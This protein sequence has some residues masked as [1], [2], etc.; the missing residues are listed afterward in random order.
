MS[1]R[2]LSE[3]ALGTLLLLPAAA[4]LV[5]IVVYPIATLFWNSLHA[6]DNANPTAA[7]PFVALSNYTR[8][9]DDERFWHSSWNTILYAIVTVP[10]ALLVGL[11]LALLANM[12]FRVKWPV[13]LGLLL[14][15]ALPL[16]FAGLIFR[17]FFE[18]QTG[19]VNDLLM[20]IGVEPLQWLSSP[21]LAFAAISIAIIWKASS[22]MALI[23]L[24][25]LQTIPRSL[26]EAADVD[27]ATRWQQFWEITLPMLLPS[28][29]VAL[30]FRTITAI[31]TFDIPFAMTGGGPGD[32]TETLA[33]YIYK[34]T[35][36][37]LDFGYGSA[38]AVLMFALSLVLTSGYLRYTQ[39]R[40]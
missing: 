7:E 35:L 28:I 18:Y 22:F 21:T 15:W 24:A 36:D 30:I 20:R 32:S 9:F 16:V 11:G 40:A 10:G 33:M 14:P 1:R 37:F 17:W 34:T 3:R 31:Q 6:V 8:A 5:V 23:L 29:I 39:R 12:P 27:G 13:R 4:L 2:D 26:Y 19:I 38:L 25:G